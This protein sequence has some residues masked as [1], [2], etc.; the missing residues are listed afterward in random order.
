MTDLT[1]KTRRLSTCMDVQVKLGQMQVSLGLIDAIEAQS[2][3]L[4]ID[5]FREDL[6]IFIEALGFTNAKE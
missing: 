5:D 2:L 1:F 3:L 6:M 4:E